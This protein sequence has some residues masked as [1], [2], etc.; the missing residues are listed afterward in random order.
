MSWQPGEGQC[1]LWDGTAWGPT[2]LGI[3]DI[4]VKVV[5]GGTGAPTLTDHGVLLGSG[6]DPI[7]ALGAMADGQLVIGSTGA[8]PVVASIT[9][10]E[11]IYTTAGAGTLTIA[12]E[13]AS[14]RNKG[15]SYLS[16]CLGYHCQPQQFRYFL[17]PQQ[18]SPPPDSWL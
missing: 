7:T 17:T 12:C 11:G 15:Q 14:T 18:S 8:D 2:D 4:P 6:T 3:T 16:P 1:F 9:A 10:G 13:D 5:Q